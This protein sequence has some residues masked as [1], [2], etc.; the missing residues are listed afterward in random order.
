M[1]QIQI[2]PMPHEQ[3]HPIPRCDV[4]FTCRIKSADLK[5]TVK[6]FSRVM[7]EEAAKVM[8]EFGFCPTWG[9]IQPEPLEDL[10]QHLSWLFVSQLVRCFFQAS[11]F[12]HGRS[13]WR[14]WRRWGQTRRPQWGVG[15]I[16][17]YLENYICL[18]KKKKDRYQSP[19]RSKI[20]SILLLSTHSVGF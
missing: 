4:I 2:D 1:F 20:T 7:A 17:I 9:F 15:G 10:G 12:L 19:W 3:T 13:S 5:N 14:S 8:G 18:K 16:P 11:I 6:T